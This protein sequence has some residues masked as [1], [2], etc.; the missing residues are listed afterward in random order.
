MFFRDMENM[1][2]KIVE[3]LN[4]KDTKIRGQTE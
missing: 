1:V 2:T 3:M 4:D